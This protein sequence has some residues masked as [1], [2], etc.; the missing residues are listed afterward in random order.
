MSGIID[1]CCEIVTKTIYITDFA[2]T[3]C[4]KYFWYIFSVNPD[5]DSFRADPSHP[6]QPSP[7]AY[8][9]LDVF[10]EKVSLA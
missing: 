5:S 8:T 3:V 1:F 10:N 4:V 7:L 6:K 2:S 9:I